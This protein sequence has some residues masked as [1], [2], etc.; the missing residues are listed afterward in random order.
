MNAAVEIDRIR[1]RDIVRRAMHPP[2]REPAF[3]A[4]QAM[5]V[6][7][8]LVHIEA[9]VH[10]F[11]N[12]VMPTGAP[13][14]PLLIPVGYAALRYGLSGSAATAAWAALLWLPDLLLSNDRGHPYQDTIQLAVVIAVALFVGLEIERAHLQQRRAEAA[15]AERRAAELHYHRLF[16]T[17]TS[18][19]LL[20]D[21]NGVVA[22]ANPAALALWGS[23]VGSTTDRLLGISSESL[24]AGRLPQ[25]V[26]LEAGFGEERDYR[27]SVSH[28]GTADRD[29]LRQIVL[30]DVTEEFL[31]GNRARAWAGAVLR[32]QED[33]CRRIAREIH[34]DPLQRLLQ[35]A[36]RMEALGSPSDSAHDGD[37]LGA[38]RKELLGVVAHLRDVTRGLHPAGLDQLGLVAA[39][40]GLLADVEVE[41]GL[42]T[43]LSVGGEPV[44][45]SSEAEV[46][47]F[48]IIQEAVRNVVGHADAD[49]LLVELVYDGDLVELTVSDDGIGFE[50]AGGWTRAGGHFGILGMRERASLLGGHCEVLS[51]PGGGTVVRASLPLRSS[52][53]APVEEPG[54]KP[55]RSSVSS[56]RGSSSASRALRT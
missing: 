14:D 41:E 27:I 4:V 10:S 1:M 26:R 52:D 29:S 9:D 49:R 5:V 8:G 20:V 56:T 23:V 28:L 42:A 37:R 35:L 45:G 12:G 53:V 36:R 43:E 46:G 33:E 6:L 21:A 51:E 50:Q 30:E 55:Q 39:V 2:V 17:N 34:D 15:E 38:V 22:E 11:A 47:A 31:A 13:I 44:R 16:D 40:R 3:W 7:W 54:G 25:T 18:P 19:I 32:A 48:R 24:G